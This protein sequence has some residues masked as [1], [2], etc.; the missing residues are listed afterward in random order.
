MATSPKKMIFAIA[1]LAVMVLPVVVFASTGGAYKTPSLWPTGYWGPLVSCTGNYLASGGTY[2]SG[3]GACTSLC[4]LINTTVNVI[5]FAMSIAIFIIAPVLFVLGG[6]MMMLSGANPEMLSKGRKTLT[7]TAIGL[8]IVLCSYLIVNTIITALQI[9]GIGGFG[10]SSCAI[11]TVQTGTGTG[12]AGSTASGSTS[13][14]VGGACSN[15][16]QCSSGVCD[17][18][19]GVC[20]PPP[21]SSSG[22]QSPGEGVVGG[23]LNPG[24]IPCG[25]TQCDPNS[26]FPNC[27]VN[28]DGSKY[29]AP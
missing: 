11:G 14:P 4:D 16:G 2:N 3:Q 28:T 24:W 20:L 29:C 22:L 26:R 10:A 27:A 17:E 21:S 19:D 23:S 18:T 7:D 13:V 25:N 1:A 6:I 12:T 5:Y 15:S 8:V 9:N